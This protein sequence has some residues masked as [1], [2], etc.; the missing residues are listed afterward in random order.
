VVVLQAPRGHDVHHAGRP[1]RLHRPHTRGLPVHW[2]CRLASALYGRL[3]R[4]SPYPHA[5]GAPFPQLALPGA[6]PTT[7]HS[8]SRDC[9]SRAFDAGFPREVQ[10]RLD[11][12][13]DVPDVAPI[14]KSQLRRAVN[15]RLIQAGCLHAK[16]HEHNRPSTHGEQGARRRELHHPSRLILLHLL[17]AAHRC[18]GAQPLASRKRHNF[19][20]QSRAAARCSIQSSG[21]PC[22]K[23]TSR[24]QV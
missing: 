8:T 22:G 19:P 21:G 18:T 11:R 13:T 9:A 2:H 6:S 3:P 15:A 20:K 5:C 10:E 14:S 4:A 12:V 23:T 1:T 16:L 24:R 7:N 17:Q